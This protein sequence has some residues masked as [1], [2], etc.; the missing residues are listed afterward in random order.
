MA[1]EG[2]EVA[3]SGGGVGGG[4]VAFFATHRVPEYISPLIPEV[5]CCQLSPEER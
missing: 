2:L 4:G 5:L 3:S 1:M